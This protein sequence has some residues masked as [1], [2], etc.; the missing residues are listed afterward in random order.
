[1]LHI[2]RYKDLSIG[3]YVESD[4]YES[5]MSNDV[6]VSTLGSASTGLDIKGLI[7]YKYYISN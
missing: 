2:K 7:T 5:I 1:M 6:S 3:T 4:S